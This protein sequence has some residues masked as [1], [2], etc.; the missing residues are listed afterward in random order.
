M[1][2]VDLKQ[3]TN[4]NI[5]FKNMDISEEEKAKIKEKVEKLKNSRFKQ[6]TLPAWRPIPSFKSTMITFTV[7][8]AIFLTL[9][10]VLFVMSDKII[11]VSLRYDVT[12]V[13]PGGI[14]P[15]NATP[16]YATFT[17]DERIPAPV[18]IY[19]QL[20]NFYQNHRRYVKSRSFDQLKGANLDVA[21]IT[22]DC[23]PIITVDELGIF[24]TVGNPNGKL[25]SGSP[26]NPCG[27]VAKSFFNDTF[28]LYSGATTK[29]AD[30]TSNPKLNVTINSTGIAWDSDKEYKFHN[31]AN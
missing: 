11:E 6:Q 19:Y 7:F 31:M 13:C 27:L 1:N 9:G 5:I 30:V 20:D 26:A 4:Y 24:S 23:D 21:T 25:P 28:L 29:D 18:Y 8:G 14:S 12:N 15:N 22:S 17:I 3:I 2:N 16:C 10:I